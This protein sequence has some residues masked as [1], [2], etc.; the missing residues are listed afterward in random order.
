MNLLNPLLDKTLAEPEIE[1]KPLEK[2]LL[3]RFAEER[4]LTEKELASARELVA[5]M[6]KLGFSP[7]MSHNA[8][9][10][11]QYKTIDQGIELLSRD[12]ADKWRH[13]FVLCDDEICFVCNDRE[14]NH[15]TGK[16]AVPASM[17]DKFKEIK[18]KRDSFGPTDNSTVFQI[19]SNEC[20]ICFGELDSSDIYNLNCSHAFCLSCVKEYLQEK[21]KISKVVD[22]N[23]PQLN[24][25]SQ[26]E[27]DEIIS[28]LD[29]DMVRKYLR[30]KKRESERKKEGY[31]DCPY[32]D[33]EGFAN[34]ENKRDERKVECNFGH[35]I[36]TECRKTFHSETTCDEEKEIIGAITQG[37]SLKKCPKCKVW[38]EK[39]TGCN[40]ITCRLCNHHWCWICLGDCP[41]NHYNTPGNPCYGKLFEGSAEAEDNEQSLF[42]MVIALASL[43]IVSY[44][45]PNIIIGALKTQYS[46]LKGCCI[47]LLGFAVVACFSIF[48]NYTVIFLMMILVK[49]ISQMQNEKLKKMLFA[50][51]I[52]CIFI[53]YFPTLWLNLPILA[54]SFLSGLSAIIRW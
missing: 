37:L 9:L 50:A 13:K 31:L 1:T 16:I 46:M 23:C 45:L 47:F 29:I 7:R 39:Y 6:I 36:C 42:S 49:N 38:T 26:I 8:Y 44:Y 2:Q 53:L 3:A 22:I 24:C 41:E 14:Q 40:H 21:I 11:F 35:S 10:A 4:N 27:E 54:I 25:G 5:E 18:I 43:F 51:Y 52:P 20:E 15:F 34:I 28:L 12:F 30:F 48:V 17:S 19:S 33:C 32:L